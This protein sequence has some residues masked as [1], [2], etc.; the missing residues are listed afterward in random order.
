MAL[1]LVFTLSRGGSGQRAHRH[2]D[3]AGPATGG[4]PAAPEPPGHRVLLI[5]VLAFGGWIG[6]GP[7]LARLSIVSEGMA[8]TLAPGQVEAARAVARIQGRRH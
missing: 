6:V 3:A 1:A 4:A 8:Y 5:A 7:V 2:A